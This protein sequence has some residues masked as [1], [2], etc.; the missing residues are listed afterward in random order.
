MQVYLMAQEIIASLQFTGG[1]VL[2]FKSLEL[3]AYM[4]GLNCSIFD[5]LREYLHYLEHITTLTNINK[6]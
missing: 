5:I 1:A 3:L 2:Y 4:W 6:A